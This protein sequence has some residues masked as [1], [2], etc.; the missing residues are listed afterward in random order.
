MTTKKTVAKEQV[1]KPTIK[2]LQQEVANLTEQLVYANKL[3]IS[4]EQ[5]I[6][7]AKEVNLYL[8]GEVQR[9]KQ[10]VSNR[11]ELIKELQTPWWKRTISKVFSLFGN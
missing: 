3:C 8:D 9:L 10:A 1:K 11:D 6:V 7:N 4:L 2:S 5:D